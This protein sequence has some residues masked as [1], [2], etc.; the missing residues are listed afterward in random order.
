MLFLIQR[1]LNQFRKRID[2]L[3]ATPK[4]P[5]TPRPFGLEWSQHFLPHYHTAAPSQLHRDICDDLHAF[6]IDRGQHR[7]YIA[8]RGSA[9]TTWISK[10]YPLWAAVEGVEPLILLLAET[11]EQARAYLLAIKREIEGNRRLMDAYPDS[12]GVGP[13]WRG[14]KIT[15]RNGVTIIARGAGGRILGLTE[16][17]KRPT[18]VIGDDMNKRG[19]AYSP[20]TR[21]RIL[22]WFL[23]DVLNVGEPRTNFLAAGT[24]IHR[25]A[26]VCELKRTG[27]WHTRSY[28]SVIHWPVRIDRWD[29][30]EQIFCDL[31]DP[32]RGEHARAFYDHFREEMDE[33][34]EV[35]WPDREPLYDLMCRRAEIGPAAFDSEKQD[36]PG[37][38]GATEWPTSYF[39]W[40]GFWFDQWPDGISHRVQSLDPS[41]GA[42]AKP[43]DY[44]PH[45]MI[46]LC[47]D[48]DNVTRLYIDADLR[49]EDVSLMIG[50]SLDHARIFKPGCL[51][52]EDNSTMGLIVPEFEQQIS[53]R[54]G[55]P[56]GVLVNL[57]AITNY[58]N[59]QLRIRCVGGY[60]ARKQIRVRNTPGGR[61]LVEQW[62]DFPTGEHDD[63]P[64]AVASAVRRLEQL[65]AGK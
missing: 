41:T 23:R 45:A 29:E 51:V 5:P 36:T 9:K 38:D 6:H 48:P 10:Q 25:E 39:D 60:L 40:P 54:L 42:G 65:V 26:V 11:G 56:V 35:L 49:R 31:S 8:P 2:H 32:E 57:E 52:V 50:R 62:R 20:T 59:K 33:G 18:L 16:S 63:G 15:L 21:R 47:R 64:D 34:A 13:V 12:T 44:Q 46:G 14:D 27:A 22:D 37:S 4:P 24:P 61:L 1:R 53:T 30:W 17:E 43:G 19:D 3:A 58:E 55:T 28:R 7:A